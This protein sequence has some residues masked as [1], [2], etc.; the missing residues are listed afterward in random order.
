MLTDN[1]GHFSGQGHHVKETEQELKYMSLCTVVQRVWTMKCMIILVLIGATGIVTKGL[2]KN[3]KAMPGTDS[4]DSLQKTAIG[5]TSHIIRE[6]LQSETGRLSGG[7]L[8]WFRRSARKKGLFTRDYYYYYYYYYD[9]NIK[10][11]IK[12]AV[13]QG[14]CLK[15]GRILIQ[16]IVYLEIFHD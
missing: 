14:S 10:V 2:K 11:L 9:N 12:Q 16:N 1:C 13:R 3:L 8:R 5:G 15:A 7:D 6:V 4:I